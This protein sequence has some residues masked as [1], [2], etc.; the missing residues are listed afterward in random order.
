MQSQSTTVAQYLAELPPERRSA[1]QAVRQVILD[2]MDPSLEERMNYGMIGY[3]VPHRVFPPGYHCDP[4][5]P[6]PYAGLASQ[7]NHM[8]LYLM[9]IYTSCEDGEE[10]PGA[11]WLR[12]R[13]TRDGRKLDMG[14][15]CIRFKKLEQVPLEVVAGAFKKFTVAQYIRQYQKALKR[16][17]K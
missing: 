4:K 17:K 7:K 1:I 2:S 13:W 8:S 16:T 6:L 15:A 12:D 11:R 9:A 10:S 3:V 14:R 5:L